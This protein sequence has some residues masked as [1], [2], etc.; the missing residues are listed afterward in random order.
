MIILGINRK[1]FTQLMVDYGFVRFPRAIGKPD[2]HIIHDFESFIFF[3]KYNYGKR[4]LFTSTNSYWD[5]NEIGNPTNVYYEKLFFDLDIDTGYSTE[6]AHKE[7]IK[8]ADFCKQNKIPFA[9]SFSGLGFHF[10]MFF[11]P[12]MYTLDENLSRT[13]KGVANYMKEEL[14]LKTANMVCAEPKRLVRIPLS[15]YVTKK[16][17]G[18]KGEWFA[19]DRNCIPLTYNQVSSMTTDEIRNLSANFKTLEESYRT[20]GNK[21]NLKDFVKEYSVDINKRVIMTDRAGKVIDGNFEY[22]E[23]QNDDIYKIT[24]LLIP[25]PCI[26]KHIFDKN[27]PHFIRFSACAFLSHNGILSREESHS[28]FDK[29]SMVAEWNDRQHSMTRRYQIDNIYNNPEYDRFSCEN[30]SSNGYCIGKTCPF[31]ERYLKEYPILV[32]E[33]GKEQ[34]KLQ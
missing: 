32:Y 15:K 4:P 21:I 28:F 16:Q 17:D 11:K 8:M 26:N 5:F 7:T 25:F 14:K 29:I 13:V 9:Q 3:F 2:Q 22:Q 34:E 18:S 23:F 1:Q 6:D 12:K 31:Y 24:Q 20:T 10:F 30:I 19:T 33:D 27:P